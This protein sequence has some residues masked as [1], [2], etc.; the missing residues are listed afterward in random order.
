M[1]DDDLTFDTTPPDGP[2]RCV[3]VSPLVRRIVAGNAGPITFTGTCTYVVGRQRVAIVDP[4]PDEPAH[5]QALLDAVRGE[6]VTHVLVTHTHRD[7]SPAAKAIVAA[8]GARLVGCGPHR[9]ARALGIDEVNPLEAS[10][11]RE[12]APDEEMREGDRVSGPGWSLVAVETPGHMANHLAFYLP[13]EKALFS[14]DHVMAWSTTVIAPPDGA[15]GAFM[16]SLDKLRARDEQLYWPGHGGPVREPQ[17][18]VRALAHHRRQREVSI[19]NR[20]AAG[21]RT[22]PAI[23]AAIYQGLR[24]ALVGAAGLSVFAHL[25]DLVARGEVVTEGLPSLDGE[26][27]L[28]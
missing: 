22:I 5:I 27:R 12:Y 28:A 8:T 9:S 3:R 17:R 16:A 10:S 1:A 21:D 2:G 26:Y 14:G 24:P 11:D 4:G 19:L 6:T 20:L 18:F 23:V 15:M 25:E 13:E 7:H